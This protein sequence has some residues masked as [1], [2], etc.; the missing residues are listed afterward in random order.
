[1]GNKSGSELEQR[2]A[3]EDAASF[4]D[5][6]HYSYEL[7]HELLKNLNAYGKN[8]YGYLLSSEDC[9]TEGGQWITTENPFFYDK[10]WHGGNPSMRGGTCAFKKGQKA[11][12]EKAFEI[13]E[14]SK[15]TSAGFTWEDRYYSGDHKCY[16]KFPEGESHANLDSLPGG[17]VI[18]G[19]DK[20]GNA[21][22]SLSDGTEDTLSLL[23]I[24]IKWILE[25]PYI[26]AAG[27]ALFVLAPL[28]T[29]F[30]ILAR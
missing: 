19:L 15:C 23:E 11:L 27:V 18:V 9:T 7:T 12:F 14:E 8:H 2:N 22:K 24:I 3:A 21:I 30:A 4:L 20:A 1:M 17:T 10:F 5:K 6:N 16:Y 29:D 28:L 25:H 13:T 26:S